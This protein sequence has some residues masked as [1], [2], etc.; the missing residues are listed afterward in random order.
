ML[1]Y[2]IKDKLKYHIV[3]VLTRN[4]KIICGS[5]F[6]IFIRWEAYFILLLQI[7][8]LLPFK[9]VHFLQI[10]LVFLRNPQ[11]LFLAFFKLMQSIF[12]LLLQTI[13]IPFLFIK[14]HLFHNYIC[15]SLWITPYRSGF[16]S[17]KWGKR[18]KKMKENAAL[19]RSTDAFSLRLNFFFELWV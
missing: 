18:Q 16:V 7:Y 15:F 5:V 12:C 4:L 11:S 9:I 8:L 1:I 13:C 6:K 14:I 17:R 2:D 3:S 10:F 19:Y